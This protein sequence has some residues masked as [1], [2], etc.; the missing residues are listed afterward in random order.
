MAAAKGIGKGPE[1]PTLTE[2]LIGSLPIPYVVG[3]FLLALFFSNL[4][5]VLGVYLDTGD[6]RAV[7]DSLPQVGP[8]LLAL[9]LIVEISVYFSL[10]LAT[11]YIRL[12]VVKAKVALLPLLPDGEGTYLRVFRRINSFG[13]PLV[14]AAISILALVL[15]PGAF[16]SPA[17]FPFST[18]LF[19][20]FVFL[21]F[22]IL[23]AFIW[24]YVS[25]TLGIYLL[26]RE[27][28]RM[29]PHTEDP[30]LGLRPLGSLMFGVTWANLAAAGLAA[31]WISLGIV[32]TPS[33][34]FFI[35]A[36]V[37][38]GVVM[39]FLPL[40]AVH[41][42]M[43]RAQRQARSSVQRRLEEWA[44]GRPTHVQGADGPGLLD[45][46]NSLERLTEAVVLDREERRVDEIYRWPF[47]TRIVGRL[48]ALSLSAVALVISRLFASQF[49]I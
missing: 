17:D 27:S 44:K 37:V 36:L 25:S 26:G 6:L 31:L 24:V 39:F 1:R 30:V 38:L 16:L 11:R 28:L 42:K 40:Y 46:M 8:G 33:L 43:V 14:I 35:V 48:A 22:P 13:P 15:L 12:Q 21:F 5:S 34:S 29:R 7:A 9:V 49:G 4:R 19:I 45:V 23:G 20:A 41:R 3:S 32:P 10:P 47:D 2:R 18:T